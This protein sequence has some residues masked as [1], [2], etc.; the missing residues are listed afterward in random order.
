MQ[1]MQAGSGV[2]HAEGGANNVGEVVQGFQIWINTPSAKKLNDPRYGTV[3]TT[4]LPFVS[5]VDDSRNTFGVNTIHAT[6]R[7]LAG[8]A[9]GTVGPFQTSQ[10]VQMIDFELTPNTT[11]DFDI[12]DGLD[13]AML[14]V[15]DGTLAAATDDGVEEVERGDIILFDA[16]SN[17]RRGIKVTSRSVTD[18]ENDVEGTKPAVGTHAILFAG[19]KLKE[20][21]AWHGPIVMNTQEEIRETFRQ[22]RS[23]DFPPKRVPWNYK[24]L[25]DFPDQ[26]PSEAE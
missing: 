10:D 17:D 9:F 23:G 12:A 25:E 19:K 15:Y 24:R 6:A 16:D 22:M 1:W 21:I 20:P 8:P 2:E 26:K 13:T 4:D 5:L 14:Y 3:P 7:V 11:I 18:N